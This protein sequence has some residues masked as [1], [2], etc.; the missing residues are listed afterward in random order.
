MA[1]Y[2]GKDLVFT[3]TYTSGTTSATIDMSEYQRGASFTPSGKIDTAT[4]GSA[5]YENRIVGV[6]DFSVS[7]KGLAQANAATGGTTLEDSLAYGAIGTVTLGP[8]GTAAGKR[9]YTLPCISQGLQQNLQYDAL[10]ELNV[11]FV[12]NGTVTYGAY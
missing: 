2:Y 9:K 8:E 1:E 11:S 5:T 12:G 7:Y 3:W 4:T 10:T 6:K